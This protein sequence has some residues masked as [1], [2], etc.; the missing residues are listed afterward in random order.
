MSIHSLIRKN[1]FALFQRQGSRST[2]KAAKKLSVLKSDFS[3]FSRL[4]IAN[5]H[6]DGDLDEFFKYKN[7]PFP[8]SLSEYGQMRFSKKSVLLV[9]LE[10]S[11]PLL[12]PRWSLGLRWNSLRSGLAVRH[13]WHIFSIYW[14]SVYSFFVSQLQSCDRVDVVWDSY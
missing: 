6:R 5:Q 2:S 1:S 8:P 12:D 7:L 3:L 13:I 9:C 14:E 11:R 4:N 10:P